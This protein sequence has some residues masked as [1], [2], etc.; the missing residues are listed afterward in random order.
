MTQYS[1]RPQDTESSG[2]DFDIR[3]K[4]LAN[5]HWNRGKSLSLAKREGLD[6]N[7][8]HWA[9]IVFLRKYYLENGLPITARTTARALCAFR[10]SSNGARLIVRT[11]RCIGHH[12]LEV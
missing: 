3:L 12:S 8:E 10:P 7:D 11:S 5:H 6:F 9:V 2:L 1:V 4:E